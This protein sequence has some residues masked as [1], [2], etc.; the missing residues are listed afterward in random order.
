MIMLVLKIFWRDW[1]INWAYNSK[2]IN[3]GFNI[4]EKNS[5]TYWIFYDESVDSTFRMADQKLDSNLN[6]GEIWYLG[7]P[8]IIDYWLVHNSE[9]QHNGFHTVDRNNNSNK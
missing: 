5:N 6:S 4:A 2:I 9:I 3:G 1:W 7:V 8:D